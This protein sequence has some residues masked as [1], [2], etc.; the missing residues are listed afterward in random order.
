MLFIIVH[1][2]GLI[3]DPEDVTTAFQ[4]VRDKDTWIQKANLLP[5]LLLCAAAGAATCAH[6]QDGF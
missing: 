1:L 5:L 4:P 3:S 2:A 6:P